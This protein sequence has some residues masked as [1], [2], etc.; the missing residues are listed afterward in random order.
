LATNVM[1]S[2]RVLRNAGMP[3][4]RPHPARAFGLAGGGP[5]RRPY[6]H[7][8][9]AACLVDRIE[10]RELFEQAFRIYWRDPDIAGRMLAMEGRIFKRPFSFPKAPRTRHSTR[11]SRSLKVAEN[12]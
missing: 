7:D 1:H 4:G 11:V 8:T 10:H 5:G 6:F 3:A 9:L 2:G 12:C